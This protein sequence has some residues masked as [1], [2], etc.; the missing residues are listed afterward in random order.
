MTLKATQIMLRFY[1]GLN[2]YNKEVHKTM[3]EGTEKEQLH[4]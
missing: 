4:I 1:E 2:L 3:D